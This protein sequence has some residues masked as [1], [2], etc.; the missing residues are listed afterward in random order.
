MTGKL[1]QSEFNT[2]GYSAASVSELWKSGWERRPSS[3][4]N[5]SFQGY[6]DHLQIIMLLQVNAHMLKHD[7]K[8]Y[9]EIRLRS[10]WLL[11]HT[12]LNYKINFINE[13]GI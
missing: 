6:H 13:N 10:D 8:N 1:N 5:N 12:A 7:S 4:F 2:A 9:K 3:R 11:F